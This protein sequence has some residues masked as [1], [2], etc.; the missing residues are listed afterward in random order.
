MC[1]P[2][3]AQNVLLAYV[4]EFPAPRHK[5]TEE[6]K[7]LRVLKQKEIM[8]KRKRERLRDTHR[9]AV[10]SGCYNNRYNYKSEGST[11]EAPTSG[12][13]CWNLKLIKRGICPARCRY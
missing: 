6:E 4:K 3:M 13:G 10:C 5:L 7:R 9:R 12:E 8:E 2:L 11:A 1:I